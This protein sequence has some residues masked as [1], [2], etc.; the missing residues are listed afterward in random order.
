[1]NQNMITGKPARTLIA[2]VLPMI[3]GN[4]FQQ[5]YSLA[6]SIIVGRTLGQDAL[7]AVGSTAAIVMVYVAIANGLAIGCSVVISQLFGSG[8][9][10]KMKTSFNTAFMTFIGLSVLALII[11]FSTGNAIVSLTGIPENI[12]ADAKSYY[13]IYA[14]GF[15]GLFFY[16]VSNSGFNALGKSRMPLFFLIIS[17]VLNIGLDL[18]FILVFH[19]GV[20]GAAIATTISQYLAAIVAFISLLHYIKKHFKTEQKPKLFDSRILKTIA[21]V[22]VPSMITSSVVSIGFVALQSL[23]NSFG[24]DAMAAYAAAVKIDGIAIVPMVQIGNATS[25]FTAQNIG[26]GQVER[27][28]KGY[29]VS[30]LM[31][32][33]ICAVFGV[34]LFFLG[35]AFVGLFMDAETSANAIRIGSEYLRIVGSFYFVMGIMNATSGVLRGAGDATF[36][37]ISTLCNFLSR[38]AFSYIFVAITGNINMIWWSNLVGWGIGFLISYIRYRGGKWKKKSLVAEMNRT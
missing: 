19:W 9:Y 11:G 16:N 2:F 37:M 12:V 30:I 17:S 24:T 5:F 35:G 23:V 14:L 3:L 21:K 36:A 28:P 32:A 33:V 6:D 27:V 34:V 10:V 7:A 20:A 15:P 25:T 26:A 18:L 4:L 8:D 13:Y 1:M 29:H 22:G 31:N 38:V